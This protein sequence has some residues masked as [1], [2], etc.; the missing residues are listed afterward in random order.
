MLDY[1]TATE[2]P[3]PGAEAEGLDGHSM[4]EQGAEP[5]ASKPAGNQNVAALRPRVAELEASQPLHR[6]AS[7]RPFLV[8]PTPWTEAGSCFPNTVRPGLGRWP[9]KRGADTSS[10]F[11][12]A[13]SGPPGASGDDHSTIEGSGRRSGG[14]CGGRGP[15]GGR[16]HR[17]S[18]FRCGPIAPPPG[19]ANP[20]ASA[21]SAWTGG[22]YHSCSSGRLGQRSRQLRRRSAGTYGA[23]GLHQAT[24]QPR[25]DCIGHPPECLHGAGDSSRRGTSRPYEGFAGEAGCI[26]RPPY[27][28]L[29]RHLPELWVAGGP[30]D[31]QH[32][33]RGFLCQGLDGG[34]ADEAGRRPPGRGMVADRVPG[35]SLEQLCET[36]PD[37]DDEALCQARSPVLGGCQSGLPERPRLPGGQIEEQPIKAFHGAREPQRRREAGK[38]EASERWSQRRPERRA[39][40]VSRGSAGGPRGKASKFCCGSAAD[41]KAACASDFCVSEG[42]AGSHVQCPRGDGDCIAAAPSFPEEPVLG[43]PRTL[44]TPLSQRYRNGGGC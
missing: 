14:R 30:H 39:G 22:F 36:T 12:G 16:A 18:D 13:L 25:R 31:C 11:G 34:G 24:G 26:V 41:L 35:A 8:D 21:T 7:T 3:D 37:D 28:S 2:L 43:P 9:H 33:S 20:Y 44:R 5:Q 40:I 32:A 15:I 23:G 4:S 19:L 6:S 29:F 27:L 17:P 38:A 1:V 10:S 42:E